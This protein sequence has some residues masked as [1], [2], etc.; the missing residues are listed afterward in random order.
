MTRL[1]GRGEVVLWMSD[2]VLM[3]PRNQAQWKAIL[4]H[5][6]AKSSREHAGIA[7]VYGPDV[8]GHG[9]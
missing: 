2:E 1:P 4:R 5:R 7:D 9:V 6:R 3:Q 8:Y